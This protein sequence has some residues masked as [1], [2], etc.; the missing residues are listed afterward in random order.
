V[1]AAQLSG[2]LQTVGL[3]VSIIGLAIAAWNIVH[4]IQGVTQDR[5]YTQY[6]DV[7][8]IFMQKPY[9]RP[10]FYTRDVMTDATPENPHL[11]DEIDTMSELILGLL[12]H[13][14]LQ[15]KL[16]PNEAYQNCWLPYARERV[17]SSVE[18]LRFLDA[19][20]GWYTKALV[21]EIS[22]LRNDETRN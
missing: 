18:L 22:Q 8:K 9:L 7:C 13:A 21:E 17:T 2:I 20:A 16:L 19:N 10:Y 6:F 11:R 3:I 1:L 15:K 12:E 14:V 4:S 5:L